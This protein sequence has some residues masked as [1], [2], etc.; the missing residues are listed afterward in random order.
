MK[1]KRRDVLKSSLFC[2][3]TILGSNPFARGKSPNEKLNIACIGAGGR[4]AQ[5]LPAFMKEDNVVALVDVDDLRGAEGYKLAPNAR[6]FYDWR[7]MFDAMSNQ[8]D[9]VVV[10]TPDHAHYHPCMA[11]LRLKKHLFCEKPLAHSVAECRII[12]Q[13]AAEQGV[14]TQLGNQRHSNEN[15][16]RV[17]EI[18]QSGVMGEIRE[19]H[20]GIWCGSRGDVPVPACHVPVPSTLKWDLWLG[21]ARKRDYAETIPGQ[22][23]AKGSLG[24]YAPYFWKFWWDFG[25]GESGNWGCHVLDIPYWALNLKYPVHVKVTGQK[26]DPERTPKNMIAEFLFPER[27]GLPPCRLVWDTGKDPEAK[28]FWRSEKESFPQTWAVCFVGSK[29]ILFSSFNKHWIFMN[30]GCE[31]HRPPKSI[32]ASPGFWKEW[33]DACKGKGPAPTCN[34]EYSGPMAETVILA[35]AGFRGGRK[36]FDWSANNMTAVNCPEVQQYIKPQF[37]NGYS[38]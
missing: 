5:T 28:K 29:G 20:A 13:T 8:I 22:D 16:R 6:K 18:I 4:G 36:S 25:T 19:V 7:V 1:V 32:P 26:P 14:Q 3:I 21:P 37:Y 11:A 35:N 9:A 2:G 33:T 23:R 34:F 17:V 12:T 10:S 38:W 24:D 30:N 15:F 27:G 31:F